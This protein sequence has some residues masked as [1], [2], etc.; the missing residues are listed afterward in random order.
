MENT[1]DIAKLISAE[2]VNAATSIPDFTD[3]FEPQIK[4]ADPRFGDFQAKWRAPICQT[5]QSNP[6]ELADQLIKALPENSKWEVSLAGLVLSI[7]N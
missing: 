5:I 4:P 6:R 2:L 3:D 1:H 7:L